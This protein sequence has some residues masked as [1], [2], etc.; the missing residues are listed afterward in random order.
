MNSTELPHINDIEWWID[1]CPNEIQTKV[2]EFNNQIFSGFI[3][4]ITEVS[5]AF[6]LVVIGSQELAL[7]LRV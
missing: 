4:Y 5:L 3:S 2:E 7:K 1:V 6:G